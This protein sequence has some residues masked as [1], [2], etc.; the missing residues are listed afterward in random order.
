MALS[1]LVYSA[2]LNAAGDSVLFYDITG[3]YDAS[4]NTGGYGAPN[5]NPG[6]ATAAQV[7]VTDYQGTT[8]TTVDLLSSY[9]ALG[10]S[11][12]AKM[13]LATIPWIYGDGYH[14]FTV[15]ITMTTP[16]PSASFST[17]KIILSNTLTALNK[18]W[19][20]AFTNG[21]CSCNSKDAREAMR[22]EVIY[23]SIEGNEAEITTT[24]S[25]KI[26]ELA[27]DVQNI[28]NNRCLIP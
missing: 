4:S 20:R 17:E 22:A 11:P 2:E 16:L 25:A 28:A 14:E 23:R 9:T 13:L 8:V 19:I 12:T 5:D 10:S 1:T 3:V 26:I 7:V 6:D 18:L 27:T 15:N 21:K 24:N